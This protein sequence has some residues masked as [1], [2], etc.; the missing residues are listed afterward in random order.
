[1]K[2][3][4]DDRKAKDFSIVNDNIKNVHKFNRRLGGSKI[5]DYILESVRNNEDLASFINSE[6][7]D[8]MFDL[9]SQ[10]RNTQCSMDESVKQL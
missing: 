2:Q 5:A 8:Q 10:L 9:E 4:Y 1:M 6:D 3:K 7:R